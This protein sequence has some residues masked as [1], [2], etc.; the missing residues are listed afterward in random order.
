M[1]SMPRRYPC[2]FLGLVCLFPCVALAQAP[3]TAPVSCT[4]RR[5]LA[6]PGDVAFSEDKVA[7]ALTAYQQE[8]QVAG[9]EGD[10]THNALIRTELLSGKV[11]EAAADAAAWLAKSPSNAWALD[12]TAE[13]SF[14]KGELDKAGDAFRTAATQSFCNAQVHADYAHYLGA[15]GYRASAKSQLEIAHKLDPVDRAITSQWLSYQP[16]AIRA[17]SLDAYLKNDTHLG[18]EK[19]KELDAEKQALGAPPLYPCRL[20]TPVKKV[21]IPFHA[22]RTGNATSDMEWG[23][24]LSLDGNSRRL[25]I[26]SGAHGIVLTRAAAASLGL[27]ILS[28]T[29]VYGIAED[30]GMNASIAR[31]KSIKIGGLEY[32]D[33]AVR[34][35]QGDV[36]V[37]GW[38]EDRSAME[39]KDGLI[40]TDVF[41][42]FLVTLDFPGRTLK[43]DP[44]PPLPN[45]TASAADDDI[46]T[47]V[48]TEAGVPHD[49]YVDPA[50]AT[51]TKFTRV[52]HDIIIPVRVNKGPTHLFIVDTGGRELLSPDAAKEVGHLGAGGP[53]ELIGVTGA[54]K[55]QY[56]TGAVTLDFS[57]LGQH[58]DTMDA[59]D[60]SGESNV[61]E[62]SGMLG[63]FTLH[64][65]TM[66][67]DYRDQLI[68]F[69]YDPSRVAH[70]MLN[71]VIDDC[72]N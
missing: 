8:S 23:L 13:V 19:R 12:A 35:L 49:R 66:Q 40:G 39:G 24:E 27:Q 64:Q 2:V 16:R 22:I 47:G 31:V 55:R 53:E 60:L 32:Q 54:V 5:T 29:R 42:N 58:V 52:D 45:T 14:R 71:V 11:A 34:V 69:S 65:L 59:I 4:V 9:E 38:D 17:A 30:G 63:R 6:S 50:M 21:T 48:D 43:L 36:M 28:E 57:G 1:F 72:Y 67:I 61:V 20:V 44:L 26:D 3:K 18:E 68:H 37:S 56:S 10:R 46:Q 62:I 51:W 15:V 7:D 33:C 25:I 70:C 41:Q